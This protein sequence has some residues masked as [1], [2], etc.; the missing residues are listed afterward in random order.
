VTPSLQQSRRLAPCLM[1]ARPPTLIQAV[2]CGLEGGDP[3]SPAISAF[4]S[5]LALPPRHLRSTV[6]K[7]FAFSSFFGVSVLAGWGPLAPCPCPRSGDPVACLE[8]ISVGGDAI[9]TAFGYFG[10][11][12]G[13]AGPPLMSPLGAGVAA[14]VTRSMAGAATSTSIW[15]AV[16]GDWSWRGRGCQRAIMAARSP[17]FYEFAAFASRGWRFPLGEVCCRV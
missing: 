4:S 2:R 10:V 5:P 11:A 14:D 7:P 13:E 15:S 8:C 6:A 1:P 12:G 16:G 3:T 17:I 9:L